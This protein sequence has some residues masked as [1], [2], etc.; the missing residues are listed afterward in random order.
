MLIAHASALDA[1]VVDL[2]ESIVVAQRAD[3]LVLINGLL[4]ITL[5]LCR[6]IASTTNQHLHFAPLQTTGQKTQNAGESVQTTRKLTC[7]ERVL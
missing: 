1:V 7:Q 6:T 4:L 2:A 3:Q 5:S